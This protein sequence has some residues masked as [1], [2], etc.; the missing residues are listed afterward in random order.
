[1][2]GTLY[3]TLITTLACDLACT[4]C[5]Q[6]DHPA[7][8]RM[9]AA[10]ETATLTWIEREAVASGARRVL[11]HYI[12]GEALLRKDFVVR[13]AQRLRDA[14]G[15]RAIDFAW[16]VTTNGVG[17]DPDIV[18][19]LLEHGPGAVKVTLDG[20]RTTHAAA[21]VSRDGRGTFDR[22][23]GALLAV[24]RECPEV[25]LRVG[26]NLR[27]GADARASASRLLDR[28][29]A[30]GLGGRLQWVRFKPVVDLEGGCGRGCGAD[31]IDADD[32]SREAF[33]RGL[34]NTALGGIDAMTPCELHWQRSFVIDTAG[35]IY[36]CLAVA[37]RREL[38]LGTVQGA[39]RRW[40]V[41]PRLQGRWPGWSVLG[42]GAGGR[43]RLRA[44]GAGG[45]LPGRDRPPLPRGISPRRPSGARRTT[46]ITSSERSSSL[47]PQPNRGERHDQDQRPQVVS[48]RHPVQRPRV[49]RRFRSSA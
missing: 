18:R 20:D 40:P 16:E 25:E 9:S 12:G 6:K 28:M 48:R 35:R 42:D 21:R 49:G 2:P 14:L 26:G 8:G 27:R 4:Y 23:F 30:A 13:T 22:I 37:G 41:R 32:A 45:A 3:V 7:A 5:F 44:T 11:V 36:R 38:A 24:A 10:T 34:A 43:G 29:E 1:M 19:R 46:P 15:A 47:T 33:E 31:P 17:L 39:M